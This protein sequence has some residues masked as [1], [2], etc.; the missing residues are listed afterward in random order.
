MVLK[1]LTETMEQISQAVSIEMWPMCG[2]WR[3]N[4]KMKDTSFKV[5]SIFI[6]S[7][8]DKYRTIT[9]P[10]AGCLRP[11]VSMAFTADQSSRI[12]SKA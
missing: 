2:G 10:V 1:H 6:F 4:N 12:L 11:Q 9:Y 8:K 5:V 3:L 7:M